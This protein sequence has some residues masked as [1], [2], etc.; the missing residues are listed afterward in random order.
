[1]NEC[2]TLAGKC[3]GYM[4]EFLER[5]KTGAR[6]RAVPYR[7]T[8]G[9]TPAS[10]PGPA[11]FGDILS[12]IGLCGYAQAQ[13]LAWQHAAFMAAGGSVID[14]RIAEF[15]VTFDLRAR[16]KEAME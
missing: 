14:I 10:I 11:V 3:I 16:R 15:E 7:M 12:S 4:A 2:P 13:A 8:S 5:E 1:M 9:G 6:W